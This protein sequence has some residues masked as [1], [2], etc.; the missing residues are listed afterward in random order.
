ME[1]SRNLLDDIV[2]CL[3]NEAAPTGRVPLSDATLKAFLS[4]VS[5]KAPPPAA[6]TARPAARDMIATYDVEEDAITPERAA[7]MPRAEEENCCEGLDIDQ[8]RERVKNCKRCRLAST[9]TQTVF[10]DGDPKAQLMF[11]GEGPGADEDA[12]GL[13]FVG[14]AGQ[15]L[16]KMIEAM[17]FQRSE[18][19]IANVVKCRPPGNRTPEKDE[20]KPCMPYLLRQIELVKPKVI[21]LLGAVALKYLL[22]ITGIIRARGTWH[23]FHGIKVMPTF[24]PA[25]LLRDPSQ[26]KLVWEDLQKV[27]KEFGKTYTKK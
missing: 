3:E 8:L 13:P 27:M 6:A 5:K 16:T 24:H 20:A 15:L 7:A 18:V 21:V 11:I 1:R 26:K 17:G 14:K 9:R 22:D 19:Y 23:E 12:Q 2:E 25:L 10:S 4:D